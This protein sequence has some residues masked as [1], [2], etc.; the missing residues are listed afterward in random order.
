MSYDVIGDIHGQA[1]K[2]EALL[3]KLGYA[4]RDG[5]WRHRERKAIFVGD[6]IDRGPRQLDT[7]DI[8]RR[9]VDAGSA[10]A[11]MGNHEFNATAWFVK[12]PVRPGE[13]LRPHGG[14]IGER[15]RSQH[16]AFL[17][18]VEHDPGL[19]REWI[20][21]F[22]TLPLWLDLSDLRVAHAC[23]HPESMTALDGWL[24][25]GRTLDAERLV[26]AS[27]PSAW[28]FTAVEAVTKG[29]G[30]A[31]PRGEHFHDKD[32]HRR[33][34]IRMR[35]WDADAVS[36]RDIAM[37]DDR[38]RAGITD[39]R[40]PVGA[41]PAYD[42]EKPVFVGHYWLEGAPARQTA[43]VAC[44]DYSAAKGGPLVAYRWDGEP[45]LCSDGFVAS[46]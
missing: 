17:A 14:E 13:F 4:E 24:A 31:L 21:W 26:A 11:V 3:G 19:H 10:L 38:S 37:L 16:A 7:L 35:W 33:R 5:A 44:V 42:G 30:I 6:F 40:L 22:M 28:Q 29:L 46:H 43:H 41:R 36:Y 27:D 8:V 2:L 20:D 18:E 9:M 34:R 23:W 25:P 1:D 12:D 39:R 45:E 15:N 32:G